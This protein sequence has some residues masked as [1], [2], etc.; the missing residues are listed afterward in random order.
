MK[1]ILKLIVI[2]ALLITGIVSCSKDENKDY[3]YGGNPPILTSSN[4]PALSYAN[5]DKVAFQL[6]WTNPNYRFSTGI[7]SQDVSYLVEIDTAGANFTNP[8][9]QT[10]SVSKDLSISFTVAQFND[11]LLNQL[12]LKPGQPHAIEIRVK[13]NLAANSATYISNT[14]SFTVTPYSIPPK[15][16]IPTTNKLYLVGNATPGGD[17][18]GW[19]NPVPTPSQQFSQLSPTLYE[20]TIPLIGGKEY[21][22][23]PLNGDWGN[24]YAVADNT[25]AGLSDGGD[26]GF[27]L[28]KNFPGPA[29]SGTYKITVDFQRGKFTVTKQ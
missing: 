6:T 27:N 28:S 20:I 9:K 18:H 11:Y 13:S 16:P 7:S 25:V 14:V 23:L 1:H 19:D 8:Q 17:A 29:A 21:L 22:L 4:V 26:F 24:K 5:A 2:A 10:V 3:Y 15:V 12:V